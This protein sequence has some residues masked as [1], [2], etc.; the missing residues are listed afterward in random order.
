MDHGAHT[1]RP[2]FTLI[3]LLVVIALVSIVV[4][5][6]TVGLSRGSDDAV[7]A[8][9]AAQ[10]LDLD[11]HAR[12]YARAHETVVMSVDAVGEGLELRAARSSGVVAERRFPYGVRGRLR[13]SGGADTVRVDRL[14][15][16]PDYALELE[17][18]GVV[19]LLRVTGLT[20]CP[21]AG[22]EP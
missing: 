13:T 7:L 12:L 2:G 14:G 11:T 10:V 16:S 4:A 22:G 1:S 8:A 3:E 6:T 21:D 15:R 5:T 17:C 20:G 9:L 18:H 19:R